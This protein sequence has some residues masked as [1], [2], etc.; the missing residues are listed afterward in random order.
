MHSKGAWQPVASDNNNTGEC[1][2][3]RDI[4][5]ALPDSITGERTP[6]TRFETLAADVPQLSDYFLSPAGDLV[7]VRTTSLPGND[8]FALYAVKAGRANEKLM[9]LPPLNSTSRIVMISWTT[10]SEADEWGKAVTS[11]LRPKPASRYSRRR[12]RI[13]TPRR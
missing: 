3:S 9:D 10:G 13:R 5:L 4:A 6:A 1:E 7:V 11:S 8:Q 2:F 12:N